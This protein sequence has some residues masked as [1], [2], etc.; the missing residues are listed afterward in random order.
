MVDES[1][2]L[3]SQTKQSNESL[4]EMTREFYTESTKALS[5]FAEKEFTEYIPTGQT[6]KSRTYNYQIDLP[7]IKSNEELLESFR[8][9]NPR[10][11]DEFKHVFLKFLI[12]VKN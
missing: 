3:A 10:A 1:I 11:S 8:N 5:E 6:P 12:L 4:N 9:L 7:T 2:S